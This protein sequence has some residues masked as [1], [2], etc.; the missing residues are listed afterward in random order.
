MVKI[1]KESGLEVISGDLFDC[2]AQAMPRTLQNASQIM[3]ERR[4]EVDSVGLL[5][6]KLIHI[7]F[8]T[9]DF[10]LYRLEDELGN[11]ASNPASGEPIVYFIRGKYSSWLYNAL[12]IVSDIAVGGVHYPRA[13]NITKIIDAKGKGQKGA[14]RIK[15][16]DLTMTEYEE[17]VSY[18][19]ISPRDYF[20]FSQDQPNTSRERVVENIF[21]SG[22]ALI[23]N[24][25]MLNRSGIKEVR[26]YLLSPDA[27]R[28][29]AWQG[30]LACLSVLSGF[31]DSSDFN[32]AVQYT[33]NLDLSILAKRDLEYHQKEE[34]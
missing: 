8:L 26:I 4:E 3:R 14:L 7:N 2:L 13:R 27:V 30:G 24:M 9:A 6:A 16:D 1:K 23:N 19:T 15:L 28:A 17:D 34:K 29:K 10:P 18:F 32:G 5:N 20:E 21:G 11:Q 22:D 25:L 12:E 33:G 31:D